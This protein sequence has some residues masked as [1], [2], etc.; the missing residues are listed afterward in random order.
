MKDENQILKKREA[1]ADFCFA[2]VHLSYSY[3]FLLLP[4]LL[5]HVVCRIASP[6]QRGVG[7]VDLAALEVSNRRGRL[8]H[9]LAEQQMRCRAPV[10]TKT[11]KGAKRNGV[12]NKRHGTTFARLESPPDGAELAVV[13]VVA[14]EHVVCARTSAGNA[15]LAVAPQVDAGVHPGAGCNGKPLVRRA[16]ALHGALRANQ[17]LGW[18][19][20][21]AERAGNGCGDFRRMVKYGEVPGRR[22]RVGA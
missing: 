1:T 9:H 16:T 10:G 17:V 8:A 11:E 13:D 20:R 3:I 14:V 22:A 5:V 12:F 4:G 21:P 6:R 18:K 2:I 15:W 19:K 7:R